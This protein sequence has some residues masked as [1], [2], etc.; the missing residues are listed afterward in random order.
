M[1][2][3]GVG[4]CGCFPQ[5]ERPLP[6]RL[7]GRSGSLG[8]L[9]LW[10]CRPGRRPVSDRD[11]QPGFGSSAVEAL[12]SIWPQKA[13]ACVHIFWIIASLNENP[14]AGAGLLSGRGIDRGQAFD[15][16]W[17][18]I[19]PPPV[20]LSEITGEQPPQGRRHPSIT[21]TSFRPGSPGPTLR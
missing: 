8:R 18:H 3:V 15:V 4:P 21:R 11:L 6:A 16:L 17:A 13:T 9:I 5:L 10:D 19:S 2:R 1:R 12:I 14:G 20:D 7:A